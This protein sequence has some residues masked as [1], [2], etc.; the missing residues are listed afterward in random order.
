MSGVKGFAHF[1][2]LLGYGIQFCVDVGHRHS[3]NAMD[4]V[5]T[6]RGVRTAASRP[7]WARHQDP[8]ILARSLQLDFRL[9]GAFYRIRSHGP[10]L[11]FGRN[12]R[13]LGQTAE[14]EIERCTGNDD[15]DRIHPKKRVQTGLPE[16]YRIPDLG[17]TDF[18]RIANED[19]AVGC[20]NVTA[21]IYLLDMFR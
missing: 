13:Q 8:A 9:S 2:H 14:Y 1:D 20:V 21:T 7:A 6:G 19:D 17:W 4:R 5:A 11:R 12:I 16:Q 15:R 10:A 3:N 18:Q